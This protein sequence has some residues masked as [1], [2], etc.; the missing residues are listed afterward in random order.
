MHGHVLTSCL[1][2]SFTILIKKEKMDPDQP[3]SR[4]TLQLSTDEN[5][6]ND[7]QK[8]SPPTGRATETTT[9][10]IPGTWWPKHSS[11]FSRVFAKIFGSAGGGSASTTTTTEKPAAE[12]STTTTTTT[13]HASLTLQAPE[14]V[15]AY[16]NS[17]TDAGDEQQ[18]Q[19]LLPRPLQ[20]TTNAI[21]TATSMEDTKN[22]SAQNVASVTEKQPLY[23]EPS[24]PVAMEIDTSNH[25]VIVTN[26]SQ[27]AAAAATAEE[28]E[29][30][31]LR[32]TETAVPAS[33]AERHQNQD[34]PTTT[35]SETPQTIPRRV[36][37][38]KI[39]KRKL[40]N[41]A[42]AT[43]STTATTATTTTTNSLSNEPI[44]LPVPKKQRKI[45]QS[46]DP[47]KNLKPKLEKKIKPNKRLKKKTKHSQTKISE[48]E[49][50]EPSNQEE[51]ET[52]PPQPQPPAST[53]TTTTTTVPTP[54]KRLT[55]DELMQFLEI[56]RQQ[57]RTATELVVRALAKGP[58]P[59]QYLSFHPQDIQKRFQARDRDIQ[60]TLHAEH[61]S[62]LGAS[63][64]QFAQDV[65]QPT[66]LEEIAHRAMTTSSISAG[67]GSGPTD[68]DL[69]P[70]YGT[71]LILRDVLMQNAG[72]IFGNSAMLTGK[73]QD[74]GS[75]L[76][77]LNDDNLT[78]DEMILFSVQVLATTVILTAL[79]EIGE[80][81]DELVAAFLD[82]AESYE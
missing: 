79:E 55:Q 8:K 81:S 40:P 49:I 20:T 32:S 60:Y 72:S 16:S 43:T 62:I 48:K 4:D 75:T 47:A 22:A 38:T 73:E 52:A 23:T 77:G 66:M 56:K 5:D 69:K 29:I 67:E 6:D 44:L 24:E 28:K 1:A 35:N 31:P 34:N 78:E 61:M 19:K 41:A 30:V 26:S 12:A 70:F 36:K 51:M 11:G 33:I 18:Q 80:T 59:S 71:L 53:T 2:L 46:K 45:K 76:D 58:W 82:I 42:V 15:G 21:P 14:I 63:L 65:L 17:T 64:D 9:T 57:I 54:S 25:V 7:N 37:R 27:T 39:V 50:S 74:F 3:P 68:E 10:T 13:E